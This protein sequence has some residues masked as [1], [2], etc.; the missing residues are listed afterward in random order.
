VRDYVGHGVGRR[1]ARRTAGAQLRFLGRM[2]AD[3]AHK[4]AT[5]HGLAIEPMLNEGTIKSCPTATTAGADRR[6][7]VFVHFEHT[8]AVTPAGREFDVA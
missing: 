1:L 4:T 8:A 2:A 5:G 7:K 3:P 6:R